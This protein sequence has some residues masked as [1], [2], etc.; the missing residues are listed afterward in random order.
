M[1]SGSRLCGGRRGGEKEEQDESQGRLADFRSPQLKARNTFER[2]LG[3]NCLLLVQ[4][5]SY[6]R[7]RRTGRAG[8]GCQNFDLLKPGYS[9]GR[10]LGFWTRTLVYWYTRK[11]ILASNSCPG[12]AP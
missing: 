6:R 5:I 1:V 12:L 2:D 10:D 7:K 9:F 3:L 4:F 11:V 8:T